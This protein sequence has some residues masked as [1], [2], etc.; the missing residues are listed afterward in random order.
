MAN[1]GISKIGLRGTLKYKEYIMGSHDY[2]KG[3]CKNCR[4]DCDSNFCSWDCQEEWED[5]KADHDRDIIL[6]EDLR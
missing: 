6:D 1:S 4:A 2:Y 3:Q 5:G